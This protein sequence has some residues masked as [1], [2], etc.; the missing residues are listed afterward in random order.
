MQRT[1]PTAGD[2]GGVMQACGSGGIHPPEAGDEWDETDQGATAPGM[3]K[4]PTTSLMSTVLP[5][6]SP[7]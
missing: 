2:E 7:V 6:S 3:K 4:V 1:G 5:S